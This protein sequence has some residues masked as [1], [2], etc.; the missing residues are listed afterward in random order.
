MRNSL[1]LNYEIS[2]SEP[3]DLC[4][5]FPHTKPVFSELIKSSSSTDLA[6]AALRDLPE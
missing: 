1:G 3:T 6:R 5:R 2:R 4:Q